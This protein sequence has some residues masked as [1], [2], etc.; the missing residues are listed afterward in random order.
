[1]DRVANS[2]NPLGCSGVSFGSKS[3]QTFAHRKCDNRSRIIGQP[4]ARDRIVQAVHGITDH[5]WGRQKEEIGHENA[6]KTGRNS[7]AVEA[8][9]R[10]EAS[11]VTPFL[12]VK[13]QQLS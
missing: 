3:K 7:A 13:H 9:V 6:H 11:Q 12:R 10:F 5:T 4:L 1:M 8:K 2:N